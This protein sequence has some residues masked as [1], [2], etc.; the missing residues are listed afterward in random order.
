[1]IRAPLSQPSL[2][3][4]P[5][6]RLALAAFAVFLLGVNLAAFH[7]AI[8]WDVF[9]NTDSEVMLGVAKRAGWHEA[10]GWI[11][12]PWLGAPL[13]LYYRP[14]SSWLMWAEWRLFGWDEAGY[15]WVGMGLHLASALLFW[16]IAVMLLGGEILGGVAAL[17]FS[18]RPR[19]VRTLAV[20]TA[21]PDLVAAA[22]MFLSLLLL[23]LYLRS[24]RTREPLG[25]AGLVEVAPGAKGRPVTRYLLLIGSLI[26]ALLSLGG[27]EMALSLPLLASLIILFD[28]GSPRRQKALLLGAFWA[29]F[30]VFMLGRTFAMSGLGYIPKGWRDPMEA[31][32]TFARSAGLYFAYP[33]AAAVVTREYWPL[34]MLGVIAGYVAA[35]WRWPAL[36]GERVLLYG[37]LPGFMGMALGF[38]ALLSGEW[39]GVLTTYP[40][41][42]LGLMLAYGVGAML[43]IRRD[44]RAA[45]FVILWGLFC[46]APAAYRVY[47]WPGKFFYIPQTF[48]AFSAALLLEGL[49]VLIVKRFPVVAKAYPW[50]G[51]R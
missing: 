14:T 13:C 40:W 45:L 47:D 51:R 29:T 50:R 3:S 36:R 2:L 38:A 8:G 46:F 22:F 37:V 20:L 7:H 18:L 39:V 9:H 15:Q 32:T 25:T 12:G 41:L 23:L 42:L 49:V 24:H 21:Q 17:V 16:R 11:T 19:N 26:A 6:S 44:H 28:R 5:A 48:W 31:I 33:F 43:V 10:V 35:A 30:A 4:R 1:M 27:K 34:A